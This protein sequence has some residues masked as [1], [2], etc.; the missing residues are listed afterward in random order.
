MKLIV[1]S[2]IQSGFEFDSDIEDSA[3]NRAD[4]LNF[5]NIF[6]AHRPPGFED[7][8]TMRK[9]VC[10]PPVSWNTWSRVIKNK[11]STDTI[12]T[13]ELQAK[14]YCQL[15]RLQPGWPLPVYLTTMQ[16]IAKLEDL[17]IARAGRQL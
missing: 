4:Q 13:S 7:A 11:R 14:L 3:D 17:M 6:S 5:L 2:S 10:Y 1:A 16:Q 8:E 9:E 15:Y 12:L